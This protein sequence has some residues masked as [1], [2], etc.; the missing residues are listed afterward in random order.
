MGEGIQQVRPVLQGQLVQSSALGLM[1]VQEGQD[2]QIQ[3]RNKW[4]HSMD[5]MGLDGLHGA[6]CKK[7]HPPAR[8]LHNKT[9]MVW[10]G[11]VV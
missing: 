9:H 4:I 8:C 3:V 10:Y 11:F 7:K 2:K 5:S 1:F 6:F